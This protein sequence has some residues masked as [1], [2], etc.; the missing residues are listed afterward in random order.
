MRHLELPPASE[1]VCGAFA[2]DESV[3]F[4]AGKD[5]VIRVWRTPPVEELQSPLEAKI[6]YL[7]SQVTVASGTGQVQIRAELD[8]PTDPN[9]RLD[10]G[11]RVNL[12]IYPETAPR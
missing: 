8:N 2:P 10:P 4:T 1:V 9:R 7:A 5:K 3:L 11:T 6:A 12:T